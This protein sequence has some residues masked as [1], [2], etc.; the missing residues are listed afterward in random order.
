MSDELNFDDLSCVEIPVS[1]AHQKYVLREASC[2]A[3]VAYRNS[4]INGATF[5]S[6]GRPSSLSSFADSEP[7]LVCRCLF[8]VDGNGQVMRDHVP[9][10]LVRS[11][12]QKVVRQ[13]FVKAKEISELSE[14]EEDSE[15]K[16]KNELN[17]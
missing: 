9:E 15:D 2:D 1:I 14:A 13:L 12:P 17:G 6:E 7:V 3:A 11:W 8:P 16:A 10:S 5:T 4:M